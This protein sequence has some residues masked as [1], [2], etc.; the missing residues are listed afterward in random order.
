MPL[1]ALYLGTWHVYS[2]RRVVMRSP[3]HFTSAGLN[4]SPHRMQWLHS[5][6]VN[7]EQQHIVYCCITFYDTVRYVTSTLQL[8]RVGSRRPDNATPLTI[9]LASQMPFSKD[10]T[11]NATRQPGQ[12]ITCYRS[13]PFVRKI[14]SKPDGTRRSP[15]TRRTPADDL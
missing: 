2:Q 3:T 4:M 11:V 8:K 9:S 7:S 13:L 5:S 14:N 12:C 15:V 1:Y 10:F 6:I